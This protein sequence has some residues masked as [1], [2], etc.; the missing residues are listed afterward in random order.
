MLPVQGATSH[1]RK[2][3]ALSF[4]QGKLVGETI[5]KAENGIR[6]TVNNQTNP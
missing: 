3:S 6:K 2:H 5:A 1:Y 4:D